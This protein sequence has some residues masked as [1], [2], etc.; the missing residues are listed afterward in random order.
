MSSRSWMSSATRYSCSPRAACWPRAR[1][2][3]CAPAR[4]WWRPTLSAESGPTTPNLPAS[5]GS[6]ATG[7]AGPSAALERSEHV[8]GASLRTEELTAGYQRDSPV[9][10]GVSISVQPGEIVSIVG[11]NG[12]GKSTLLKAIVG[13]VEVLSGHVWIGEREVTG[14]HAEAV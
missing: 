9:V 1:W 5:A 8:Q 12:S 7:G 3:L 4:R 10:H 6:C 14:W 11:P 2:P 13:V